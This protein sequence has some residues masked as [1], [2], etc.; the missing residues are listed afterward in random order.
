MLS[1]NPNYKYCMHLKLSDKLFSHPIRKT[2]HHFM[3]C[4]PRAEDDTISSDLFEFSLQTCRFEPHSEQ[5]VA[6]DQASS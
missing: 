4:L 6:R 1:A 2:F 3:K 5:A